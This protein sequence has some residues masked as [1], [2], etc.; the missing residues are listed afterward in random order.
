MAADTLVLVLI[1]GVIDII[2]WLETGLEGFFVLH[3]IVLIDID[4]ADL[5]VAQLEL[6]EHAQVFLHLA[7][8][9]LV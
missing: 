6:L 1:D 3:L 5:L 9:L 2:V 7:D 4:L 8:E